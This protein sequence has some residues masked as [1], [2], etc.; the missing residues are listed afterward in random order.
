MHNILLHS[1]NPLTI[2]Y[3]N[4]AICITPHQAFFSKEAMEQIAFITI[5]NFSDFENGS[6]LENESK[7]KKQYLNTA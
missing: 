5:N 6:A 2:Y 1:F 7:I 4:E 3:L